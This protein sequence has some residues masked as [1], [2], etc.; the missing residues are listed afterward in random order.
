MRILSLI[1]ITAMLIT[2]L[3]GCA[4]NSAEASALEST[5]SI[6]DIKPIGGYTT[7]QSPEITDELKEICAKALSSRTDMSYTPIALIR[8]QVVAGTNYIILFNCKHLI[9]NSVDTYSIGYIYE[10]LKGISTCTKMLDSTTPTDIISEEPLPGGL[11]KPE[12]PTLTEAALNA[13]NKAAAEPSCDYTPLALLSTQVVAGTN[14]KIFCSNAL[15]GKTDYY[16][17]TIYEDLQG[18]AKITDTVKLDVAQ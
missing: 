14:Y 4:S 12:T 10:D 5:S 8:T 3:C 18:N 15:V 16:I 7:P 17:L 9:D 1:T 6:N 11:T 13:F 2:S